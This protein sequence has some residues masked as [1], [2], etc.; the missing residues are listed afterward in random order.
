MNDR[1]NLI[2][3]LATLSAI[4]VLSMAGAAICITGN[5][6][7]EVSLAKI[8]GAISFLAAAVTG[9]VGIAGTFKGRQGGL[10]EDNTSKMLDKQPPATGEALKGNE[11]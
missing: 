5:F 10:S 1:H 3:Y 8:I 11:Q 6:T 7:S 4:V 2:A 9:L